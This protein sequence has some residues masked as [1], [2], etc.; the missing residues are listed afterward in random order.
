MIV[1]AWVF[2]GRCFDNNPQPEVHKKNLSG[3]RVQSKKNCLD[4]QVTLKINLKV[5]MVKVM[6]TLTFHRLLMK[7]LERLFTPKNQDVNVI[8]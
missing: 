1:T 4:L 5:M 6:Y 7:H 8:S 2:L 3:H